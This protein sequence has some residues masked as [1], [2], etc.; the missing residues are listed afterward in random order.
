MYQNAVLCG[1]GL[2]Y[3]YCLTYVQAALK[4]NKYHIALRHLHRV[5]S[6]AI[7]KDYVN[8]DGQNLLHVLAFH[9]DPGR[10]KQLQLK[11]SL[12]WI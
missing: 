9:T 4:T 7:V 6:A 8:T 11:V 12:G 10:E 5:K 1:N 2:S 3:K